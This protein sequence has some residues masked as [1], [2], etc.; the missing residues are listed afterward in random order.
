MLT[1]FVHD[2]AKADLEALRAR[3]PLAAGRILAL[4]EQLECD[5]DL[6]DRL[7][8]HGYGAY[9]LADFHVSK[10]QEQWRNGKDLWRLKVWDLEKKGIQY[11]IV[12]AFIPGK[13]QYHILAITP[14]R[15]FNYDDREPISQ[16]ILRAYEDL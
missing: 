9:G 16:R 7:T 11:R 6:L 15:N 12:Y 3:Q 13:E 4:L 2:D 1:L 8:Q 14:R 5:P 10:W